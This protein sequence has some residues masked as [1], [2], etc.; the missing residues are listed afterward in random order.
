MPVAVLMYL[1][2]E[3][4]LLCGTDTA[5]NVNDLVGDA[6]LLVLNLLIVRVLSEHIDRIGIFWS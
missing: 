3:L 6:F 4:G 5:E 2:G 1:C